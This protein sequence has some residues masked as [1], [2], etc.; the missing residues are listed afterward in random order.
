MDVNSAY[1]GALKGVAGLHCA[2]SSAWL[3]HHRILVSMLATATTTK[4]DI[5]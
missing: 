4:G 2:A 5:I 3:V 1:A